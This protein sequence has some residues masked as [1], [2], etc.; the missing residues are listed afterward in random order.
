MPLLTLK[1]LI[2]ECAVKDWRTR[3][4]P[5]GIP[6]PERRRI[7]EEI[8]MALNLWL[9]AALEQGRGGHI[10]N[11]ARFC[12]GS[13]RASLDHGAGGAG[14]SK[15]RPVFLLDPGMARDFGAKAWRKPVKHAKVSKVQ[16][17]NFTELAIRWST[18]LTK[19][20]VF[21]GLRDMLARL[22]AAIKAG[23]KCKVRFGCGK[24]LVKEGKVAFVFDPSLRIRRDRKLTVDE[25][26]T[27]PVGLTVAADSEIGALLHEPSEGGSSFR[28]RRGPS[29]VGGSLHTARSG[30]LSARLTR[31]ASTP[32]LGT[33]RRMQRQA[34]Q[35][36]AAAKAGVTS[37]DLAAAGITTPRDGDG[38]AEQQQ[39]QPPQPG[40]GDDDD[41]VPLSLPPATFRSSEGGA[42]PA[43]DMKAFN[44][45]RSCVFAVSEKFRGGGAPDR[46]DRKAMRAALDLAYERHMVDIEGQIAGE[47]AQADHWRMQLW[48]RELGYRAE[49]E[50]RHNDL[51]TL[52]EFLR[53][54]ISEQKQRLKEE[55]L[56]VRG[57]F[58]KGKA[59][60]D[61]RRMKRLAK[62]Y[63]VRRG[64]DGEIIV[65]TARSVSS[66]ATDATEPG[67]D[68]DG[69]GEKTARRQHDEAVELGAA[70]RR[71]IERRMG[72]AENDRR[73]ELEEGRR[74]VDQIAED[75]R[76]MLL[77]QE[78]QR[79]T[80]AA[81]LKEAW[82]RDTHVRNVLKLRRKM[83][84]RGGFVFKSQPSTPADEGEGGGSSSNSSR[85]R[86]T[87]KGKK[88]ARRKKAPTGPL[89]KVNLTGTTT[90]MMLP[91]VK[92]DHSVGYD[93][94]TAR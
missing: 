69:M 16:E 13:G 85:R 43:S 63:G 2:S 48:E 68:A 81:D 5:R 67:L 41:G 12:W 32:A 51:A 61:F 14:A 7:Y 49:M 80:V 72:Q 50:K 55:D 20:L 18:I 36:H 62:R 38:A 73:H 11:F 31:A 19:D 6:E 42:A 47:E 94:R 76:K 34:A 86:K 26:Q 52:D 39:Q 35:T 15:T 92:P 27:L 75:S 8:W 56:D 9:R 10:P 58:R 44:A 17:M 54:Q 45:D 89:E 74:F 1:R 77:M 59:Y 70:L 93:M 71:Q 37:L 83:L 46:L 78:E 24:L 60:P 53:G 3:R 84:K 25:E 33:A 22:R 66:L 91:E 23:C 29:G 21:S 40:E 88:S 57:V 28:T 30:S 87:K 90:A 65:N 82:D 79:A 4:V 64:A